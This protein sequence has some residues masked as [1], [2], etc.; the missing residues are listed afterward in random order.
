MEQIIEALASGQ[1]IQGEEFW[2][3]FAFDSMHSIVDYADDHTVFVFVARERIDALAENIRKEYASM[4]RLALREMLV[5]PPDHRVPSL[6]DLILEI[7]ACSGKS[8]PDSRRTDIRPGY[9][10]RASLKPSALHLSSRMIP[11]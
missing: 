1:E 8:L 4:Y 9:L 10:L 3:P 2:F 5:P 11:F 6:P 7:F